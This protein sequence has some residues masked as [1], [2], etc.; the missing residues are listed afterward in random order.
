[1]ILRA[2][3]VLFAIVTA[4]SWTLGCDT[5]A[6]YPR[7]LAIH[8]AL[9]ALMLLAWATDGGTR[10]DLVWLLGAGAVAHL[11]LL[12][13]PGVTS[14]DVIR[15][16][17]DGRVLL[18]GVDPWSLPPR[19][20]RLVA[21]AAT[22]PFPPIHAS[23]PTAYPPGAVALFAL[24]ATAGATYAPLAWQAMLSVAAIATILLVAGIARRHVALVAL[25][26]L[27]VQ[28]TGVGRHVDAFAALGVA[29]ALYLARRDAAAWAGIALAAGALAKPLCLAAFPALV[30][31][32]SGPAR[33]RVGGAAI[34]VS[35]TTYLVALAA[36][37]HPVGSLPDFISTW[38]FGAPAF[39]LVAAIGGEK[40]AWAMCVVIVAV[41]AAMSV[42]LGSRGRLGQ[43][44][45]IGLGSVLAASPVVFPWYLMSLLP[46]VALAP[47][48]TVLAWLSTVPFTYE[49]EM[50]TATT[51]TWS[52]AAWPLLVILLAA[53]AG[54][55][56][57]IARASGARAVSRSSPWARAFRVA[58]RA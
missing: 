21:L 39:A 25:S 32:A 13:V 20:P 33:Q 26:P 5:A 31:A 24:V 19:D 53:A 35:G 50:T 40:K 43:A 34:A 54:A 6:M 23:L 41:G 51:G 42:R 30:A 28:E 17:W 29:A 4:L 38:R 55:L 14:T 22:W 47:S 2:A 12:G 15:Y 37:F 46:A 27:L 8:L 58:S 45:L 7:Y 52:P 36:G 44:F 57:D 49:V 9:T 1:M 10:Q 18:A 56:F 48:A 3:C 11:V 16:L